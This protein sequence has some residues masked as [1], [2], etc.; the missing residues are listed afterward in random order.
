MSA[1]F[2]DLDWWSNDLLQMKNDPMGQPPN[3]SVPQAGPLQT[4]DVPCIDPMLS[5]CTNSSAN[6]CGLRDSKSSS[7]NNST[8]P[9]SL[10][11]DMQGL[12]CDDI[13]MADWSNAAHG[14]DIHMQM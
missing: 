10:Y 11:S 8:T 13:I 4:P 5:F 2:Q 7:N 1:D 9:I 12:L 6:S 3:A 14:L